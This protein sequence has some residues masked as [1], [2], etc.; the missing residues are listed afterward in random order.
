MNCREFENIVNDLVRAKMIDAGS[1][2]AGTAHAEIC[3]RCAS[4][5]ADE[6]ALSAGLRSLAAGDEGKAAPASVEALLLEAFRAGASNPI[7]RRLPAQPRS[8][9]RWALAAAAAILIASGFIAYSAIQDEPKKDNNAH[10]EKTP[11]PKPSGDGREQVVKESVE[12][13]PRRESRAPRPRRGRP[14]RLNKPFIIDGM[15]TYAKD[16]E[17]A[18]DFFPLSYS[19]DQKPM[20]SGKVIR[21]EMPRSALITFGMPVN[22]ERADVPIKA[23]LLVGEDGLARAIRFVR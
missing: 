9:P 11:A 19:G 3:A 12:P 15:T 4:R 18:T 23:D 20:E 16:S 1:L 14:S 21:V 8:W 5:L 7:S 10:T 6:R 2:M 13:A 17:Y 22:I